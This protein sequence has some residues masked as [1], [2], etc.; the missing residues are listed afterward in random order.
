MEADLIYDQYDYGIDQICK[1]KQ[2]Y[3]RANL[4]PLDHD[5]SSCDSNTPMATIES[6]KKGQQG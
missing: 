4:L 6:H 5:C 1:M 3:C 2:I